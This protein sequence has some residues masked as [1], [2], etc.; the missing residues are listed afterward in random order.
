MIRCDY[1]GA[2]EEKDIF[3]IGASTE[4]LDWCM[5]YGTGKMACPACYKKAAAEGKRAV[6]NYIK[7]W[8]GKD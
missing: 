4:H 2:V 3:I 7:K 8:N 1:C 5:I 6:D